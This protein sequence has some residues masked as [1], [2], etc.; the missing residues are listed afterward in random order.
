[1]R[2]RH[3][4]NERV[5]RGTRRRDPRAVLLGARAV[6]DTARRRACDLP[7]RHALRARLMIR[8]PTDDAID[9][10]VARLRAGELIGLPTET[11]YGLAGDAE[12]VHAVAKIFAIKGRPATHPVIVHLGSID[13]IDDW[14]REVSADARR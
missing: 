11:V 3:A 8:L 13:A 10:A 5:H 4:A 6:Q 1:R 9:E 2:G 7:A 14:A 12:N